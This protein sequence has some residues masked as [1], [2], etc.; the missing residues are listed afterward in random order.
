MHSC[1]H[2]KH[3]YPYLHYQT[4]SF[5]KLKDQLHGYDFLYLPPLYGV[6]YVKV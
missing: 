3:L 1:N 4:Q 6:A 5:Q 2:F